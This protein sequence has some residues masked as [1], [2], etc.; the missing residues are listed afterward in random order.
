[1]AMIFFYF[2]NM[3]NCMSK[4][5]VDWQMDTHSLSVMK[6]MNNRTV[7]FILN[8]HDASQTRKIS[9]KSKDGSISQIGGSIVNRDHNQH[10]G[11]MLI[12]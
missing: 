7:L 4:V 12:K 5:D 11:Y 10:I 9:R 8:M 3:V 6:W 1:M 2:I